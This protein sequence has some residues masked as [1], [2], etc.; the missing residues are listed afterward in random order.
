M[1]YEDRLQ[2]LENEVFRLKYELKVHKSY[3]A[4]RS[5]PEWANEA[6]KK[7]DE[8]GMPMSPIGSSLDYYRIV[9]HLYEKGLI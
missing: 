3:L 7:A 6:A 9:T 1:G 4:M 8:S 2:K 5:I